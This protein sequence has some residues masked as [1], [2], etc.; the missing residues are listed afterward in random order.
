MFQ[1]EIKCLQYDVTV[2]ENTDKRTVTETLGLQ[3]RGKV[4][5]SATDLWK[6]NT[7]SI[8]KF[9]CVTSHFIITVALFNT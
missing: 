2:E 5:P 1:L 7:Q 4:S 3:K 8:S 9:K 6:Q